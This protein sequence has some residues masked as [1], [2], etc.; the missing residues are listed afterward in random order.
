[1]AKLIAAYAANFQTMTDAK[2][3]AFF[4]DLL[5]IDRDRLA[6]REK[7]VPKIRAV[8]PGQK[9]ARFF[10][11]RTSSTPSSMSRWRP[12]SHSCP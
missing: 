10:Q 6:V 8:L 2:A 3:D 4:K 5:A 11:S 7:A 12:R 1:M 9:A